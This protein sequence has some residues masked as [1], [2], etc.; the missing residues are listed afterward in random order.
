MEWY[1]LNYDSNSKQIY[2][3]N[4]FDNWGFKTDVEILVR[5]K[6]PFDKFC[7]KLERIV[8]YHFWSRREYEISAGD[9]WE[10]DLNNYKRIDV[11]F[12]VAPNIKALATYIISHMNL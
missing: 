9:L 7:E 10:K 1:V 3:F 8:M 2:Q 11:A 6:L 4:I 12:Q 5:E